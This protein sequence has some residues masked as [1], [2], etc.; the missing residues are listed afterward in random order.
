LPGPYFH[1]ETSFFGSHPQ[2]N[3]FKFLVRSH[4]SHEMMVIADLI[5]SA[6]DNGK[7]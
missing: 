1:T 3:I 6:G 5:A 7:P 4:I 2:F